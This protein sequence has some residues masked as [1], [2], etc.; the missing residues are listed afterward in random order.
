MEQS[1]SETQR[2]V[3]DFLAA[4]ALEAPLME[5]LLDLVSEVGELAQAA[6]ATSEYGRA[7]FTVTAAWCE[8]LGDVTFALLGVAAASD[9]D[10]ATA[11]EDALEKLAR[12][13][14]TTGDA[15]SGR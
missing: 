15:A 12:R 4:H 5:R 9:V 13:L 6:L 3:A 1:L 14:A 8:E 7:P 11:L 2:R 10:L